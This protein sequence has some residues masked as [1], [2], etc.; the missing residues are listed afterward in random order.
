[1]ASYGFKSWRFDIWLGHLAG[2]LTRSAPPGAGGGL[3]SPRGITAARPP[4]F[5]LRFEARP[6]GFIDIGDLKRL[7][8]LLELCFEFFHFSENDCRTK[9]FGKALRAYAFNFFIF[10][11][12]AARPGASEKPCGRL[13]RLLG[14]LGRVLSPLD[15]LLRS[16]EALLEPPGAVL[17]ASWSL[18]GRSWGGLGASWTPL[19]PSWKRSKMTPR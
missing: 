14:A 3:T 4:F 9:C 15:R 6:L 5:I 1:M 12:T 13:G 18:L 19:G 7:R 2:D 10:P 17:G 8:C 11:K 16:L